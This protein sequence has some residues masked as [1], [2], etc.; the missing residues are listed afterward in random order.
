MAWPSVTNQLAGRLVACRQAIAPWLHAHSVNCSACH[1]SAPR[2]FIVACVDMKSKRWCCSYMHLRAGKFL[3]MTNHVQCKAQQCAPCPLP[4]AASQRSGTA[5][6]G[7]GNLCHPA[8]FGLLVT[9]RCGSSLALLACITARRSLPGQ[10]TAMRGVQEGLHA[11]L[12][13]GSKPH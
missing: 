13:C 3:S 6:A 2:A 4:L 10:W 1:H 8:T 12:H 5:G 11:S 7:T 9:A